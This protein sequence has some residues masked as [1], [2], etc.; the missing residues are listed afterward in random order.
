MKKDKTSWQD[1]K[2]WSEIDEHIQEEQD[3]DEHQRN[4]GGEM[5][6]IKIPIYSSNGPSIWGYIKNWFSRKSN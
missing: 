1:D 2:S 5:P 4:H 3:K 6:N